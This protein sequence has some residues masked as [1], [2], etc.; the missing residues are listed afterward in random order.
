MNLHQP[1]SLTRLSYSE[2]PRKKNHFHL[3]LNPP[4]WLILGF[5]RAL[6][7]RSGDPHKCQVSSKSKTTKRTLGTF[8]I[9]LSLVMGFLEIRFCG[10]L[11]NRVAT[12]VSQQWIRAEQI[13]GFLWDECFR[14]AVCQTRF[15]GL[16]PLREP[17][18]DSLVRMECRFAA[19]HPSHR[20][21]PYYARPS[22]PAF[23]V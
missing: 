6:R 21:T 23:L 9:I 3:L 19:V 22:R 5:C 15:A 8:R 1:T 14:S 2:T 17:R 16:L 18:L 10:V 7:A 11:L 13:D 4:H 20:L 12:I